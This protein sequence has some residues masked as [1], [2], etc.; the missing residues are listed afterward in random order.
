MEQKT[1][2][3]PVWVYWC[4]ILFF[5]MITLLCYV[6]LEKTQASYE[7]RLG[8]LENQLTAAGYDINPTVTINT[9]EK[10]RLNTVL[11]FILQQQ[12]LIN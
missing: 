9:G 10:V 4:V 12:G 7:S 11:K 5:V 8:M 2:S 1:Y 6:E 3:I